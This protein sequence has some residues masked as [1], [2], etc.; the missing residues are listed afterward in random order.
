[1]IERD[2]GA[3]LREGPVL[4]LLPL[5]VV[6]LALGFAA[7]GG[8]GSDEGPDPTAATDAE[9]TSESEPT[10]AATATSEA[11]ITP[12]TDDTV[13]VPAL[14]RTVVQIVAFDANRNI[15]WT[16]SGTVISS[17]GLILTN[18]HVVDDRFDEY[19]ALGIAVTERTDQAPEPTFIAEI[20]AVDYV[21]DI[22]VVRV[23]SD[24]GGEAADLDR[25]AIAIGD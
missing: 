15:V 16:G 12:A 10:A 13:G 24:L 8:G 25:P 4:R 22:A 9:A 11:A 7:C 23:V 19:H 21:L 14:A 2:K 18:A 17:D 6:A 5:T 3:R 1:M 20:V